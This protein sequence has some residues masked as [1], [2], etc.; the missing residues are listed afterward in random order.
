MSSPY[1][2][3]LMLVA[4]LLVALWR[5]A[6]I[7]TGRRAQK[8][9]TRGDIPVKP[10]RAPTAEEK[11]S[12]QVSLASR[13]PS[14]RDDPA[15]E[16]KTFLSEFERLTLEGIEDQRMP[17]EKEPF[18]FLL[19]KVAETDVDEFES[20]VDTRIGY[21]HFAVAPERCRGHV[22]RILGSLMRVSRSS[23]DVSGAD[24]DQIWEGQVVDRLYHWYSFRVLDKPEG[25]V[26]RTDL[27]E[28]VGVFHKIIVYETQAGGF[29]ATPLIIAKRLKHYQRPRSRLSEPSALALVW[30]KCRDR[31]ALSGALAAVTCVFVVV[32]LLLQRKRGG[33]RSERERIIAEKMAELGVHP[34]DEE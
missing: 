20:Y 13:E 6:P 26:S 18:M 25:F 27:V 17:L 8:K 30:Q 4:V 22:V 32:L 24:I 12:G 5:L 29:K 19:R 34:E 23:D 14:P 3:L 33:L 1:L 9:T 16:R 28:L 11:R 10:V 7:L 31:P 15:P 21:D 2:K